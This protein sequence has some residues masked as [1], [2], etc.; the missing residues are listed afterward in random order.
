M[1]P[2]RRVLLTT[3]S[4]LSGRGKDPAL[5]LDDIGLIVNGEGADPRGTDV[6]TDIYIGVSLSG[7]GLLVVVKA[8]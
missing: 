7:N 1:P 6:D 4:D 8:G 2:D 3:G 5:L